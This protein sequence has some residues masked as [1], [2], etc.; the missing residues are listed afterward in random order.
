MKAA[1]ASDASRKT[2][3]TAAAQAARAAGRQASPLR[4]PAAAR[5]T[6]MAQCDMTVS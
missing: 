4:A 2:E 1:D 6:F 3:N 5:G